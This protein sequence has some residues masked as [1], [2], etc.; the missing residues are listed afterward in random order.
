VPHVCK[1]AKHIYPKGLLWKKNPQKTIK[2]NIVLSP[3]GGCHELN[4]IKIL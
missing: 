4:K 3:E 1:N 2:K